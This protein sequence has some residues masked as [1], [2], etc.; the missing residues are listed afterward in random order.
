[1]F[2]V[3]VTQALPAV[4]EANALAYFAKASGMNLKVY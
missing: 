1:M 4:L 2:M 3:Q